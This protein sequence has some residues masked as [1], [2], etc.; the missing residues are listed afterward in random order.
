MTTT[1]GT[2][3]YAIMLSVAL[4]ERDIGQLKVALDAEYKAGFE[5]CLNARMDRYAALD[6]QQNKP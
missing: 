1:E 5:D 3:K 6:L 2:V 4:N